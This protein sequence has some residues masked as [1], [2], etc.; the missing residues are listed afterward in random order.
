MDGRSADAMVSP[1]EVIVGSG[2]MGRVP[3]NSIHKNGKPNKSDDV[4]VKLGGA[5]VISNNIGPDGIPN[6]DYAMYT[7][8]VRGALARDEYARRSNGIYGFK[9]GKLPKYAGGKFAEWFKNNSGWLN[10]AIPSA[11]GMIASIG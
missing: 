10:N 4:A 5:G 1:G 7:G 3:G 6:S 8:D 9:N 2:W 11:L